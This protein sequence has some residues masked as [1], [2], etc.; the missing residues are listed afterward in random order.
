[1]PRYFFHLRNDIDAIDEDGQE[2]ADLEAAREQAV[3]YAI[4]MIAASVTEQR[5]LNLKHRIEVADA[6]GEILMNV[7]FGEAIRIENE[8]P[9]AN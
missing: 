6:A 3:D 2:L 1:M 9:P 4:D 7:E 8:P 5:K